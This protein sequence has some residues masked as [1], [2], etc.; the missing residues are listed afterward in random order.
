MTSCGFDS[1]PEQV[2][3]RRTMHGIAFNVMVIGPSGI[4][5]TTLINSLFDFDYGD[6]PD[7]EREVQDVGLRIK[8]FRPQNK[9]TELK[10][11]IVEVKGFN[12]QLDKSASFKP[13]V[14]Y[15]ASKLENH[16][17]EELKV[18]ES[19]YNDIT[20]GRIHCCIYMISPIGPGLKAID[21]VTMKRLHK[22]VNLIPV[23]GKSDILSK[24]ERKSFIE[25]VRQQISTNG[26][27]I[28]SSDSHHLPLAISASNEISNENGKRRRLRIYPWGKMYIEENSD[29]S[30]LRD[31]VLRS[32]MLALIEATDK[33]YDKFQLDA[34]NTP[35]ESTATKQQQ[36]QPAKQSVI[37]QSS[38]PATLEKDLEKLMVERFNSPRR[39]HASGF[40]NK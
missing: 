21:L 4:G 14:N 37:S 36:Q 25:K 26:I 13:I 40:N 6:S 27:E 33:F 8:E 12:N 5:K 34:E 28:Y 11:T 17:N 9:S 15:I 32:N 30:K 35:P 29:F 16:L 3:T 22:R 7:L 10:L 18:Q 24:Q 39:T 23:I 20:D 31:L 1:L 2:A 19:R 38:K